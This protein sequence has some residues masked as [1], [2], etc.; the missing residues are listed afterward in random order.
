MENRPGRNMRMMNFWHQY[1]ETLRVSACFCL[2][3]IVSFS[4]STHPL[5]WASS[6][7]IHIQPEP[8]FFSPNQ[9]I[10]PLDTPLTWENRT[11]EAH[12]IVADD[13]RSRSGCSF[14]SG[15]IPPNNQ[16]VL[17]QLSPG[18]Y[19]YH[20]G[21]HPFM[22]GLLIIHPSQPLSSDI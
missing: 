3:G 16:F 4:S 10:I 7:H 21:L 5:L 22:R 12:S 18:R 13:C 8:P 19:P 2:L 11:Y 6:P 1:G 9:L 17:S 15:I 14:D 20:C